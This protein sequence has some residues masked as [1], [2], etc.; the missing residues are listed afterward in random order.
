[1]GLISTGQE[2]CNNKLRVADVI[3]IAMYALVRDRVSLMAVMTD[4][5]LLI[6]GR[7]VGEQSSRRGKN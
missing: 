3:R 6:V 2:E 7:G 5:V 4:C 1:M